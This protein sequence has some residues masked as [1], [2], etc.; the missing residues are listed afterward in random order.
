MINVI[1]ESK[2][3]LLGSTLPTIAQD[4]V[5]A[6]IDVGTNSLHMVVAR[7]Q[8]SL[9]T[10][11]IVASE[12]ATVR[13]G[14]RDRATGF[15]T[16]QAMNMAIETLRRFQSIALSLNA[17]EIVAVATSAVR[18]A[19][20]G[21]NFL[22]QV[23]TELGLA[24]DLISG[25]EEARRIYLGVLS[26]MEFNFHPHI[27]IDIGGGSTEL[28]LGDGH[29]P[30]MLSSTKVGAV[31]LTAELVTTDPI[32]SQE[33][34]Y[35]QAYARGMLERTSEELK[36]LLK[37]GEQ[38]RLVGTSGTI[39]ALAILHA[40]EKLGVVP[41]PLHGYEL[42]LKDLREMINRFRKLNYAE[43][44]A[45]PG[46]SDRRA[47][48]I[49]AG[50][51]ILQE[52]MILLGLETVTICERSLREGVI[53]DWMLTHDL[54]ED[55]LRFQSSIRQSSILQ[56]AKKYQV[57]LKYSEQVA[58]LAISL[59]DQTQGML[60]DWGVAERE[61][62]WAAA[63]L[64][65][66]GHFISHSSHHKHSYYL[67]RHGELLGYTEV[68][69]ETIAN[70]ARY[71]RKSGPK[72]KHDSY[73]S[74]SSKKN[75]RMVEQLSPILRLAVALDRRQI[76]AVQQVRFEYYPE[77]NLM[78]LRVRPTRVDDDCALELWSLNYKKECFETEFNLRLVPILEA[79]PV[80][81]N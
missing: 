74:I 68:E 65:N 81:T 6:A 15:L 59:F 41:T 21:R 43:R 30:R 52:A 29:E 26:G 73:R 66:C 22:R 47:E 19:P 49:V 50:A 75:R 51:V 10:F 54:I 14:D 42:P 61:L 32:A 53:V 24:I 31:R 46:M 28:I 27:I 62:L 4:R 37:P 8:P 25:Q 7:V 38:P 35:L 12:K 58:N 76:G 16:P 78:H 45:I 5:L 71:H 80:A 63:L 1:S 79:V 11:T 57:N 69:I 60:H 33:F 56:A 70:L 64:H 36:S 17:E 20:N 39:E 34:Q 67:I 2:F 44:S 3:H 13:L 77:Q 18:E 72:K 23:E 48:I 40:R 9:P 55:R